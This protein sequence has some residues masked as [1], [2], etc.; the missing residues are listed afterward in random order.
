MESA[1]HHERHEKSRSRSKPE[2]DSTSF[3][4]ADLPRQQKARQSLYG[5]LQT[6][7]ARH[8]PTIESNMQAITTSRPLLCPSPQANKLING[9]TEIKNAGRGQIANGP[10][11][12]PKT[13]EGDSKKK[14]RRG[15]PRQ[16]RHDTNVNIASRPPATAPSR[17]C[18]T[19]WLPET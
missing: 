15:N 12:K 17:N 7:K 3:E 19:T 4:E 13:R 6:T 1:R 2:E 11:S 5:P 8:S 10:P 16:A 9:R 14:E 18:G